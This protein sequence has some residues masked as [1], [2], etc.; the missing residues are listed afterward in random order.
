MTAE[1]YEQLQ[2]Q[3]LLVGG[4]VREWDID[5]ALEAIGHAD[6]VGPIVDPT[7]WMRGQASMHDYERMLRALLPFKAVVEEIAGKAVAA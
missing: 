4:L 6:S 3:V 2:V 1:E 7:A 5:G